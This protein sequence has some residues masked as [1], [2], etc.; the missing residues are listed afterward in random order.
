ME[1]RGKE[2]KEGCGTREDSQKR[3]QKVPKTK[4]EQNVS[5]TREMEKKGYWKDE[6]ALSSYCGERE[7]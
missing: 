4:F 5:G 3:Q 7:S 1:V 2:K 6:D